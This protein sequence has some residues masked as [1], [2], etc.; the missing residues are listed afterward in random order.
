MIPYSNENENENENININENENENIN[1]N[2]NVNV[3][4]NVNVNECCICLENIYPLRDE[5]ILSCNHKFHVYCI[6]RWITQQNKNDARHCC[7]FC[8]ARY[9]YHVLI[10]T[11]V[12]E[13]REKIQQNLDDI[14]LLIQKGNLDK[15]E[16]KRI[17][18]YEKDYI[19]KQ[20]LVDTHNSEIS[21][22][23]LLIE[24]RC[25]PLPHDIALL[26]IET[27]R[28]HGIKKNNKSYCYYFGL[29]LKRVFLSIFS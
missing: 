1:I 14:E 11:I 29:W 22:L 4:V 18:T 15:Y 8:K 5:M 17:I 25:N 3:N 26:I 16:R 7:P 19:K 23:L 2:E 12:T 27:K 20:Y 6:A 28:Q 21:K 10:S 9:D 13:L 24:I